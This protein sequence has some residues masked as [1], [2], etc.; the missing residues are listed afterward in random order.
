MCTR[1]WLLVLALAL[2]LGWLA[3]S[4]ESCFFC[5]NGIPFSEEYPV[6]VLGNSAYSVGYSDAR[7]NPL[8][9]CYNVFTVDDPP[10]Y[11]RPSYF[12]I[13]ERTRAEVR[14]DEYTNSGYDLGQMAPNATI[15]GRYGEEAQ[16][17]TFLMSNVCPQTPALNRGVWKELEGLVREWADAY[18]ELWVITGPIFDEDIETLDSGVETPDAFFK[19]VIDEVDGKPRALSFVIPQDPGPHPALVVYLVSVN[20]VELLTGFDFFWALDDGFEA[21]MEA[22]TPLEIW[23]TTPAE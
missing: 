5:Y 13:D 12:R 18:E 20:M 8:W 9:V 2:G 21:T 23:L 19:I 3:Q 17:E 15:A 6:L 10:S 11:D 1:I 22:K 16:L 4:S 14:H 7:R